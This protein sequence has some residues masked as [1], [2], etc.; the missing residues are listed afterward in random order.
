M[1]RTEEE[2]KE[3]AKRAFMEAWDKRV[4]ADE[5]N[6]TTIKTGEHHFEKWWKRN[7]EKK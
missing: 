6:P 2:A 7:V 4:G 5:M 3:L 1:S